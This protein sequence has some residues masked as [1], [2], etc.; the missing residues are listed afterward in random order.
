MASTSQLSE[1]VS[2]A[3]YHLTNA[4][5][6]APMYIHLILSALFPIYTGAHAS[7]SRPSSAA[8]ADKKKKTDPDD[9]DEDEDKIQKMEGMSNKDAI[10]LPITAGLVLAGLYF[11][12]MKYGAD[13]INLI[14][15]YYFSGVG[16][17]SVAKLVNDGLNIIVSFVYPTYYASGGSLWKVVGSEHKAIRQDGTSQTRDTPDPSPEGNSTLPGRFK[18]TLWNLRSDLQRK[19]AVSAYIHNMVDVRAKLTMINLFSALFGAGTIIYVNVVSKPWFLTNLQGFAVSYSALQL[20]SPTTFATG[21]LILG[22]LFCYDI[23]AVFF[24]P[25]M[26]TVAK[27][28]DQPIQAGISQA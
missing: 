24:T 28:L 5:P 10:V 11:L 9:E 17:Y 13:M 27:N 22:S 6:F 16:L 23:W 20:M 1:L 21:S 8:E 18:S 19:Y 15:G 26:V 3:S 14:M 7:L 12:I 2:K 25:L 4:R